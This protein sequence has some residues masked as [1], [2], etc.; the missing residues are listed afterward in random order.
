[1]RLRDRDYDE[2][3]LQ[4]QLT[5]NPALLG[6]GDLTLVAK[7]PRHAGGGYLDLLFADGDTYYSVEVQL[8]GI[9]ASHAFRTLEYRA[10]W[11]EKRHV[12]VIVA[13]QVNTRYGAALG[14]LAADLPIV[15]VELTADVVPGNV[16]LT[17]KTVIAHG[18]LGFDAEPM[19]GT[20]TVRTAED[21]MGLASGAA[22]Q[23][24]K[25]FERFVDGDLG[26]EAYLDYGLIS[27][28]AVRRRGGVWA[29]V[30]PVADGLSINVP[31]PDGGRVSGQ[32]TE[33]LR[34]MRDAAKEDGVAM[35]WQPASGNGSRPVNFHLRPGDLAASS[36]VWALR[37]CWEAFEDPE[38]FV[39]RYWSADDDTPVDWDGNDLAGCDP[40]YAI[41]YP[42]GGY[43]DNGAWIRMDF[44]DS[45]GDWTPLHAVRVQDWD[46]ME[47]ARRVLLHLTG[48]PPTKHAQ[49][50][51]LAGPAR[52]WEPG[53]SW[54]KT[55]AELSA[56]E[57][58]EGV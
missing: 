8:G 13:E 32:A 14:L 24:L 31:D 9:D 58:E 35:R 43:G 15:A 45:R 1:M 49:R 3:W 52:G 41:D 44:F 37:A 10:H 50:R 4:D 55:Q 47:F 22:R 12:A 11:P 7:E 20:A 16:V 51:F 17:A 6:L 18:P 28:I 34:T 42:D 19:T 56:W 40:H 48:A 33:A 57:R 36:V 53:D 39:V 5:D 2:Y 27:H 23:A 29:Q 26:A 25:E 21:W 46:D 30:R 38:P 54:S